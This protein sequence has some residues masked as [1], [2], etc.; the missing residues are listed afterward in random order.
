MEKRTKVKARVTAFA[1]KEMINQAS[2][3]LV[4][5]H[6]MADFDSLGA[7]LGIAKAVSDLG[8]PVWV[9]VDKHNPSIDKFL[10]NLPKGTNLEMF[11]KAGEISRR[12]GDN[13]LLIVVDT[14]KPSL[15][16]DRSILAK[17]SQVAII[18]HHRRGEDLI[19][20]ARLVYLETYASST[21]ELVTELL[22]YL[23][24]Q[25]ELSKAEATA[26]LAGITVD[27]KYFMYQTGSRTFE[28]AA[29]LRSLGAEPTVVQKLLQ[30]DI[31]TV[32]KKAEVICTARILYGNI[33]YGKS[34][35][36][37]A[38]AQLLAAKT[39]DTL[40]N[41]AGVSASFVL[42]PFEGGTAISARSNGDINVHAIMEKMGGG[43]H[44]TVA[45]AQLNEGL[46][47]AERR[48]LDTLEEVF[49]K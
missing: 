20:G 32:I 27:T 4:M 30:D 36:P 38:D 26:L 39:A 42:W 2:Q 12:L 9:V 19:E 28:A 31:T 47:E 34:L 13:T 49:L 24:D 29:Y 10:A 15:L 5:G 44:F 1:L 11:V 21:S 7:A 45:A 22:Q 18:D 41:I 23:G 40:L 35:E 37:F 16:A 48:L 6:E 17:A 43:G 25:V 14:H 3:V 33:V 8:R 46:G